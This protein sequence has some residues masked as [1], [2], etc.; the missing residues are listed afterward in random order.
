M[1]CRITNDGPWCFTNKETKRSLN[2]H[3]FFHFFFL[4]RRGCHFVCILKVYPSVTAQI[5]FLD[6]IL[7]SPFHLS[8]PAGKGGGGRG[9]SDRSLVP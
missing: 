2:L 9:L 8:S 7:H 5:G 1:E 6:K 3:F 4:M